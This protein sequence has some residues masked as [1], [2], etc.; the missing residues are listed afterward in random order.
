MFCQK[1]G[2]IMV[3]AKHGGK[4]RLRCPRCKFSTI[5]NKKDKIAIKEEVKIKKTDQIEVVDKKIETLP[6]T[7]EEC[8]KCHHAEAYY[9]VVQTR[10]ADEAPTQFFKCTKCMHTWRKY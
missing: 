2:S 5:M 4:T 6:K 3:P 8:P 7:K 9:W 10:S 1:C